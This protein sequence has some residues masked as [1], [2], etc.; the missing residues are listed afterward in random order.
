M[1]RQAQQNAQQAFKTGAANAATG[2]NISSQAGQDASSLYGTL[3]PTY[4]AE[5]AGLPTAGTTAENTAV[6]QSVGGSTA[7]AVGQGNLEAARTRNAGAFQPS[8]DEAVRSGQRDLSDS[9]LAV[10]ANEVDQ[11]QKGLSNLYGMNEA[12]QLGGLNAS[13]QAVGEETGAANAESNAAN[14]GWFQNFSGL[15]GALNGAG[16]GSGGGFTL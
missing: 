3:F 6:Q 9:A 1:P 5:A 4:S 14:S 12:E 7:G 8:E 10:K 11:G 2:Q 16:K 15:L 13:N